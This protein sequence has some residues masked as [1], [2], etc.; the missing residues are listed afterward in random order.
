MTGERTSREESESGPATFH[1][2]RWSLVQAAGGA[3][4]AAAREA[5]EGLCRAYWYP[6]YLF[7]RRKGASPEQAEDVVQG[8]FAALIETRGLR[9]VAREKGRFRSFLLAALQHHLAN[10]RDHARAA[11]RGGGRVVL[12]VDLAGADERFA[13]E[14]DDALSPEQAFE[15]AWALEVL[16]RALTELA[17]EYAASGRGALFEALKGELEGT[18]APHA[19]VAAR[20]GLSPGAVKTAAHRLRE[21]FGRSLRA[22]VAD[23]V[24]SPA[25][26]EGELGALLR[27]LGG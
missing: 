12:A 3:D 23:T 21:R 14:P 8:F 1:T 4:E 19:E 5:L 25:A 15:R 6:L 26:V 10:Q 16:Q 24:A 11:R 13:R 20:L 22:L 9:Q 7:A 27:A 2:T 18:P 17:E